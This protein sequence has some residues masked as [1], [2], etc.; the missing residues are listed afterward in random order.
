MTL[1]RRRT[2]LFCFLWDW[3]HSFIHIGDFFCGWWVWLV[4]GLYI[5]RLERSYVSSKVSELPFFFF[6]RGGFLL[7]DYT[8][9]RCFPDRLYI[10]SIKKDGWSFFLY[11]TI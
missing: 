8:S 9:T 10:F 6:L 5:Y 7:D 4:S 11:L 2:N 3:I 1:L